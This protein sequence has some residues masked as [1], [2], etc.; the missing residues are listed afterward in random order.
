[1]MFVQG[2]RS[3]FV[4]DR[5]QLKTSSLE[6]SFHS[7]QEVGRASELWKLIWHGLETSHV[8]GW[9][10]TPKVALGSPPCPNYSREH[11]CLKSSALHSTRPF[12]ALPNA[13]SNQSQSGQFKISLFS[14]CK[15][16]LWAFHPISM[17]SLLQ[18]FKLCSYK[19]KTSRMFPCMSFHWP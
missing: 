14:H 2:N 10:C 17:Y 19:R 5:R 7:W 11:H 9:A 6:W 16:T 18:L 15:S 1:M 12:L 4:K 8:R 13:N 3:C